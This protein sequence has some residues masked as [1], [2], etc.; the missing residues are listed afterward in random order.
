MKIRRATKDDVKIVF[1]MTKELAAYEK[2]SE[3]FKADENFF[4]QNVLGKNSKLECYLIE[5]DQAG[6]V[7][8]GE[9][10][11]MPSTYDGA[12]KM[13]LQDFYI[14]EAYRGKGYGKAFLKFLAQEAL[15]RGCIKIGWTVYSWNALARTLY[16]KVGKHHEDVGVYGMDIQHI[17]NLAQAD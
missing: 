2:D 17:E 1:Q 4:L 7:G 13:N 3:H 14:R 6:V 11:V 12:W 5:D 16:D 10:Y 8:M 15:A 9:I